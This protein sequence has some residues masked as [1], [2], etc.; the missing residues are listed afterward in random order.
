MF[1]R[2][3]QEPNDLR[4]A[5]RVASRNFA[6]HAPE[7]SAADFA[8]LFSVKPWRSVS[9]TKGVASPGV[10]SPRLIGALADARREMIG[11]AANVDGIDAHCVHYGL[12]AFG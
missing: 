12:H 7:V 8:Y 5:L 4:A 10:A 9:P 6:K 1:S 11:V 2:A 3:C